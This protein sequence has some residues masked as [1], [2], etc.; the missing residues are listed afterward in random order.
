[1]NDTPNNTPDIVD[2][3]CKIPTEAVKL[4]KNR[5][6]EEL[7]NVATKTMNPAEIKKYVDYLRDENRRLQGHLNSLKEAFVGVQTQK[8]KQ[9]QMLQQYQLAAKTQIQF[10][11]DTVAQAFKTLHYMQPL[12]DIIGGNE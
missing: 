3:S 6:I 8:D 10:C 2:E 4:T 11:K 9:S 7:G 1:M 12:E 5:T